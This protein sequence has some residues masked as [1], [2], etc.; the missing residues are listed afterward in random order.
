MAFYNF[1]RHADN[2]A[3]APDLAAADKRAG[4]M[5]LD[6]AL[7]GEH[8]A[9]PPHPTALVLIESERTC[10][11]GVAEARSLLR[12]FVQDAEQNRYPTFADLMGY[13]RYSA[14]PVGRYLLRLHGQDDGTAFAASDA[15]CSAL[16][17][18]NHVQDV[19][20]DL[21]QLNR[22][23]LPQDWLRAEGASTDDL[24]ASA[25]SPAVRR[26]LDRLL[27]ES[28]RLLERAQA[29][30]RLIRDRRLRMEAAAILA[31]AR[32]LQARLLRQDP[33]AERVALSKPAQAWYAGKGALR[34]LW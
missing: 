25:A 17:I 1:V 16:Q 13:C 32:P 12:A 34:Q 31:V 5:A 15:L 33:L 30:P 29:L 26:V 23:Y 22:C 24:K 21:R 27:A 11:C 20:D 7:Q 19:K 8:G 14:D 4:L 3:D 28:A 2:L 18:L 6:A 10:G 9:T